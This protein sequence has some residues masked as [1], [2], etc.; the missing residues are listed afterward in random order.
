MEN[1]SYI[2]PSEFSEYFLSKK[3]H[4]IIFLNLVIDK[5]SELISKRN[6]LISLCIREKG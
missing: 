6:K 1:G 2:H 4:N 5:Y 3:R